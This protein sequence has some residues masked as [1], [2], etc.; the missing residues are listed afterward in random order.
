M[1]DTKRG[2]TRPLPTVKATR[3]HTST[4]RAA[5]E[6]YRVLSTQGCPRKGRA[7]S[8][9]WELPSCRP[10][11]RTISLVPRPLHRTPVSE[12]PAAQ[13]QS[14]PGN[15]QR[16]GGDAFG[17][18]G[19]GGAHLSAPAPWTQS[20]SG[21]VTELVCSPITFP[22]HRFITLFKQVY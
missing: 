4:P 3:F 18:Q 20:C 11:I 21:L 12:G 7:E 6:R 10:H 9:L 8:M 14:L 2:A 19:S 5:W 22:K 13:P 17:S 15:L 1:Q 16:E